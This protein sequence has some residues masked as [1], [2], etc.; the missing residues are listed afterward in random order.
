[1]SPGGA[2]GPGGELELSWKGQV[3]SQETAWEWQAEVPQERALS[4]SGRGMSLA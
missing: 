4:A 3:L 2:G 1:M